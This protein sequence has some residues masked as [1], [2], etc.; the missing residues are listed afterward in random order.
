MFDATDFS[1]PGLY[2]IE[3]QGVLQPE[4]ADRLGD[5]RIIPQTKACQGRVTVLL[6]RVSDQVE[7]AGIL[8]TLHALHLPLLQLRYLGKDSVP[9]IAG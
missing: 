8:G 7:L 1:T 2:C 4:Y 9:D 6:G 5:M 3:V